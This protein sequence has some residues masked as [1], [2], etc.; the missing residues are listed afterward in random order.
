[1]DPVTI[2]LTRAQWELLA[3]YVDAGLDD[4]QAWLNDY[5][6]PDDVDPAAE[7]AEIDAVIGALQDLLAALRAAEEPAA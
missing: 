3:D 7:Q 6:F 2:T 1:M 4:K 5:A